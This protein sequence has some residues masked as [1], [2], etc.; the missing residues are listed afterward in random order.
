LSQNN[1]TTNQ[2]SIVDSNNITSDLTS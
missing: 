1:D 2:T